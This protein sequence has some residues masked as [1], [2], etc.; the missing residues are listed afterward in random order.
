MRG[1]MIAALT[2]AAG[3]RPAAAPAPAAFDEAARNRVAETI[4][5]ES[6]RMIEVMRG[7]NVDS[8]L[9][10]YGKNTAYVGNGEI[11]DWAA[12]LAGAPPRYAAYTKVDCKW[13]GT[14]RV[15]VLAPEAAVVTGRLLC[16]KADSSG[17]AW[18]EDVARTE[19][20]GI[21]GGRWRIVAVHESAKSGDL[22]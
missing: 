1:A 22:K 11:G 12:I 3:C 8:V 21:E 5:S 18:T 4:R 13:S 19:V 9:A 14:L 20:M 17:K 15:D 6:N 16:D 7:R 2:L 10:F